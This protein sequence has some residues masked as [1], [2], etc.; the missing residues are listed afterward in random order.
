[1]VSLPFIV[2]ALAKG[3]LN[4]TVHVTDK[5]VKYCQRNMIISVTEYRNDLVL[6]V[7]LVGWL[8]GLAQIL[9]LVLREH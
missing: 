6:F 9:I 1:M 7:C 4:C 2:S 3:A 5:G 8:A